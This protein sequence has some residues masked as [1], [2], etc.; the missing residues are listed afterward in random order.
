MMVAKI[1]AMP[2][3]ATA[4]TTCVIP[5]ASVIKNDYVEIIQKSFVCKS[6]PIYNYL[7]FILKFT[8]FN[9]VHDRVTIDQHSA[10][11]SFNQ[12]KESLFQNPKQMRP[13]ELN[14]T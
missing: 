4:M 1:Q 14:F 6:L 5:M 7:I 11:I 10:D 8:I 12:K 9:K 3:Y 2:K 13:N